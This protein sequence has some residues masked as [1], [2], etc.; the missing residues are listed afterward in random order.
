MDSPVKDVQLPSEY[1]AFIAKSRYSRWLDE[2]GRRETWGE[3]VRRYMDF[4][5]EKL[6]QYPEWNA[7]KERIEDSILNLEAMPSMR[8]MMTAGKALELDNTC[9]YNCA[10]LA[11]DHPRAFDEALY[12]LMCGTGVGFSVERE[13]VEKLPE[14]PDTILDIDTVLI[15]DDSK[16]G[17]AVA[18]K[19]LL[20][21]L[22]IGQCP[23][24]DLT[25]LRPAGAR[26]KTFGG[27]ASGPEPLDRLFRFT[28]NLF[29]NATGRQLTSLECH[30]LMC[31]IAQI[32]VVGG[33]RRSA[34][35]SLS[36]LDD[37]RMR[38]AKLGNFGDTNPER[39]LSNNSAVYTNTPD[40]VT[41]LEE[42]TSLIR[43]NSGERGI[44]NRKAA[45]KAAG[46]SGRRLTKGIRWGCNPCSEILLRSCQFCN[47]SEAIVRFDDTLETLM[48]KI[49]IVAILGTIQA[50]MTHFP[51]LR[52]IWKKNSEEEALLG[53][54]ITG[55]FNHPIL[56]DDE[57]EKARSWLRAL[58]AK[59]V[60]VNAKWAAILGIN[61]AAAI[62]AV[63]PSG[64]VSALAGCPSGIHAPHAPFLIRTVRADT[65]DPLCKFMI[66]AG[67][68]HEPCVVNPN[69]VMVFFFPM[70]TDAKITRN[71]LSA[72]KHLKIWKMYQ[73]EWCEHKPSVTITVR[74][75]EWVGVGGWVYDNFDDVT[76][77][78][79]LPHSNS[80]YRQP[81][82]QECTEKEYEAALA[83]MPK[84]TDWSKLS[85][86][87][88]E[89]MTVSSQT[90]ACTGNSCELVDLVQS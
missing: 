84:E 73:E 28:I 45:T 3:T 49:E 9:L 34:L 18:L 70:R 67:F 16:K 44:F 2:K 32:V 36:D 87:E 25:K 77:V 15:V 19:R 75:E 68:P 8:G 31:M 88:Q 86:F 26:L 22:W 10:Y 79:F 27:R 52:S 46:R 53:V 83:R 17:W 60:E 43:S 4:F 76:G 55:V 81:P 38:E 20:A 47:L 78:A 59:A 62:T 65:K 72:I 23:K 5:D 21:N 57:S 24:Y 29:R 30:D 42:W 61:P 56:A 14:I 11:I 7:E 63:K 66:A 6:N 41:F 35:I 13:E 82:Y 90:Y 37:V 58:K 1:Q 80:I 33:V 85:E 74:P 12:I 54:S 50:S 51:Y 40:A 64:T 48:K 69:T 39:Y 89:D 71:N